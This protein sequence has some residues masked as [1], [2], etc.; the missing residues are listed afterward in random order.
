VGAQ[1][2]GGG[3][4][5]GLRHGDAGRRLDRNLCSACCGADHSGDPCRNV[6]H[7][8]YEIRDRLDHRIDGHGTAGSREAGLRQH[9]RRCTWC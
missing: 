8:Y 3:L 2:G 9:P 5:V 1:P 7:G 6:G 4:P